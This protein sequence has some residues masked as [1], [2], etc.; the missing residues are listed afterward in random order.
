[1]ADYIHE[2]KVQQVN[3]FISSFDDLEDV[4]VSD[5]KR[6]LKEIL[7]E[8]P[9]VE[10]EYIVDRPLNETTGEYEKDSKG[11]IQRIEKLKKIKVFFTYI[12]EQHTPK[13]DGL[14]FIVN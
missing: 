12:D 7:G 2:L 1:M 8:E 9:G 10:F 4:K 14:T 5:I 3:N 13:F 11:N 6:G